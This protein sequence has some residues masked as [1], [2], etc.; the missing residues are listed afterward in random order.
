MSENILMLGATS[1]I[2]RALCHRMAEGG[3]RLVLAGRHPQQLASD[4]ADLRIRYGNEVFVE[5]FDAHELDKLPAFVDRC[6]GRF[7][8]HLSGAVLC[9]GAM[10]ETQSDVKEVRCAI[11][12]NFTSA[13]MV[14]ALVAEHLENQKHGF[15]AAISSVA[16]DRGRQSNYVYGAAKAGLTAYL[17]GLRNRLHRSGVGVLTVK[18]GFVDTPMTFGTLKQNSPLLATPERV[19]RDI[20]QA[21]N[22]G[23][24]ILYTPWF[25]RPVMT[26]ISSLP[27]PVFKRLRL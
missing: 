23:K 11:E 26:L 16:G 3:A 1:S 17:S 22:R 24:N 10:P 12:T 14:L 25:W 7:N 8:G 15:I 19:A 9:Y 21:I 5:P 27:E 20:E 13:A 6:V 2:A 18:P 4:A